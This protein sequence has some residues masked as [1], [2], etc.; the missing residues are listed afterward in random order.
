MILL[1]S[2]LPVCFETIFLLELH[3][4]SMFLQSVIFLQARD[5]FLCEILFQVLKAAGL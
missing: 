2:I 3:L 5:T 4:V 1:A